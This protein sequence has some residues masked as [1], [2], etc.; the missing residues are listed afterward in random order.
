MKSYQVLLPHWL[1]RHIKDRVNLFDLSFSEIIRLQICISILAFQ[2]IRFPEYKIDINLKYI[3][4]SMKKIA[5]K[6]F[7]RDEVL[8]LFSEIYFE[9]RIALEYRYKKGKELKKSNLPP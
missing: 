2:G 8:R 1:E 5:E 6:E 9:T 3:S 4:N 7:E